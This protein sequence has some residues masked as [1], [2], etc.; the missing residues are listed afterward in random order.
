MASA[1]YGVI[2]TELKGKVAGQVFQQGNTSTILRN[3][4]YRKGSTT[5]LSSE[6]K[7]RMQSV[8]QAWRNLD[9]ED[10]AAWSAAAENWTFTNKFGVPYQ[11]SGFQVF[12]AYN[13]NRIVMGLAPVTSPGAVTSSLDPGAIGVDSNWPGNFSVAW[14]NALDTDN[15]LAIYASNMI[16]PG[17][18]T[19]NAKLRLVAVASGAST[20]FWEF[21]AQYV[22]LYGPM[23]IGMKVVLKYIMR[24]NTWP[25]NTYVVTDSTVIIEE[26]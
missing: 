26:P 22:A 21:S 4:G 7:I 18:N 16:S 24:N 25:I 19:N 12:S 3:K 11:G 15:R 23:V 14:G 1:Q 17:R 5:N 9:D 2:I 13:N 10:R 6:S 20:A 8:T